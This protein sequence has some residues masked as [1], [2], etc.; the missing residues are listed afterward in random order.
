MVMGETPSA[1]WLYVVAAVGLMLAG[2]R[3]AAQ[4]GDAAAV[5]ADN[6]P[7]ETLAESKAEASAPAGRKAQATFLVR[8]QHDLETNFD[9]APGTVSVSR[10]SA[11]LAM[12]FPIGERSRLGVTLNTEFSN[13]SFNGATGFGPGT[14]DPW[15]EVLEMGAAAVYS[16]QIDARWSYFAGGG[17]SSVAQVGAE[18]DDSLS[19]G[20]VGGAAYAFSDTLSIGAGAIVRTRL[21][22]SV[23]VL[24]FINLQWDLSEKWRIETRTGSDYTGGG[25]VYSLRE[26]LSFALAGGIKSREFR[27]DAENVA[28]EGV[29]RDSRAPIFLEVKWRLSP[30]VSIAGTAGVQLF[31]EYTLFDQDGNELV[32]VDADPTEFFSATVTFSF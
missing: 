19:V 16:T 31:Q 29:G 6:Q 21:E 26:D 12:L 30:Q 5:K 4:P 9:G 8:G 22:D 32:Q 3:A 17:I 15:D 27:L 14:G 18:F 28:A 20:A 24:P 13:Y 7:H 1:G 2:E 25:I 23:F 10:A 11:E